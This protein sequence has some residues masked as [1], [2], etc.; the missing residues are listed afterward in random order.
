MATNPRVLS[1]LL[2]SD[3][4][5]RWQVQR[6]LAGASPET[7]EATRVRVATEAELGTKR[8]SESHLCRIKSHQLS[9]STER[10]ETEGA[11]T[12]LSVAATSLGAVS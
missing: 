5:I 3:P 4:A 9:E 7:W 12:Q 8:L 11:S 6:D 1:W 10:L 2:D